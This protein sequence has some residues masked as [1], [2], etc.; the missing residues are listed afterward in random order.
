MHIF[1]RWARARRYALRIICTGRGI[2]RRD[3]GTDRCGKTRFLDAVTGRQRLTTA[4]RF[5]LRLFA[6]DVE[7]V[8]VEFTALRS[9]GFGRGCN[10]FIGC[11]CFVLRKRAWHRLCYRSN[12]LSDSVFQ[13][14]LAAFLCKG[15]I[16]VQNRTDAVTVIIT[17]EIVIVAMHVD[18]GTQSL[19]KP[20][21]ATGRA[22]HFSSLGGYHTLAD[23]VLRITIWTKQTHH[24]PNKTA[25]ASGS[26]YDLYQDGLSS[27]SLC[28]ASD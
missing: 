11:G 6:Q 13:N 15:R 19:L 2:G 16:G 28:G 20:G 23:F 21:V 18:N 9:G 17:A 1:K 3:S 26:Q 7:H 5:Q 8:V 4:A 25:A 27:P 22:L 12:G 14:R 10:L 24:V